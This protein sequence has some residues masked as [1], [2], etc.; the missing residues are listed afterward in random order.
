MAGAVHDCDRIHLVPL[1]EWIFVL[2]FVLPSAVREELFMCFCVCPASSLDAF[3]PSPFPPP[4][5]IN[6]FIPTFVDMATNWH[7]DREMLTSFLLLS[8]GHN[9][10][11]VHLY[12][13]SEEMSQEPVSI[14]NHTKFSSFLEQ[15]RPCHVS[16]KHKSPD[17]ISSSPCFLLLPKKIPNKMNISPQTLQSISTTNHFLSFCCFS[18]SPCNKP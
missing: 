15:W 7:E 5:K 12:R 4:C 11:D 8:L 14:H 13:A 17:N 9:W 16:M 1:L 3:M 10:L 6:S 2:L 18:Y